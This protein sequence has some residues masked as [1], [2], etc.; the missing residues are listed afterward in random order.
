M[1]SGSLIN[2]C[3]LEV[4]SQDNNFRFE[5]YADVSFLMKKK[6]EQSLRVDYKT[7]S[8]QS[9]AISVRTGYKQL[10]GY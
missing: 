2:N 3:I 6:I 8:S 1:I 5:S 4:T 9:F 7:N 10:L